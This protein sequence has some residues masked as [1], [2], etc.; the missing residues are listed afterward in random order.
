MRAR[1]AALKINLMEDANYLTISA[2]KEATRVGGSGSGGWYRLSK[3]D[4]VEEA[5]EIDVGHWHR[6]GFFGDR[7][8]CFVS[9]WYREGRQVAAIDVRADRHGAE[10]SYSYPRTRHDGDKESVSYVVLLDWTACNFGGERPWFLCPG[11]VNGHAC[12]RRVTKLYLKRGY[13]LCRHC[14][15]LTYETRNVGRKYAEL[16]KCQKI[17]RRLGGSANMTEPFPPRPKGMHFGTYIRLWREHEEA[18]RRY[19]GHMIADLE[20][21]DQRLSNMGLGGLW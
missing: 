15:G 10:L 1:G 7:P 17:R 20:K 11:V 3:K 14:H 9:T 16:R 5:R 4:V 8:R 12:L 2:K 18:N 13:F 21:L 19:T 6:D